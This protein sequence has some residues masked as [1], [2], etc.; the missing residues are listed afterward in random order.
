[1]SD[2]LDPTASTY[3]NEVG[4]HKLPTKKEEVEFFTAYKQA[5]TRA[6][7]GQSAHERAIG[8][9]A[10]VQIGQKI[11]CG[12]LRFVILQARRKTNDPQLLKDLI[13]QGNIGLMIGIVRFD[14]S[15]NVRFLTYAA[16]W[17]NVCMQ[18]HLHK[19]GVVHV[20]SHTRKEMRRKKTQENAQIALG[21]I[22][23]SELEEPNTTPIEGLSIQSEINTENDVQHKE[24]D[25]FFYMD[26]AD[27]SRLERLILVYS[28]GL[29]GAEMDLDSLTQFLFEL[30]GS[31]FSTSQ[32][33][34]IKNAAMGKI[35]ELLNTIG[36]KQLNEVW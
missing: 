11:A 33:E 13:S 28:F 36:I 12:Y 31:I 10:R 1:M 23:T 26:K 29:R 8:E 3:F 30:D 7:L 5:Q 18:E 24:S 16:S 19:L 25:V 4:K 9:Q 6:E 15:H 2:N 22:R 35:K 14:L 27:L 17:I 34:R 32:I 21:N 20:P